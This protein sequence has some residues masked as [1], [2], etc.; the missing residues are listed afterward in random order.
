MAPT[1]DE[2][3]KYDD[4]KMLAPGTTVHHRDDLDAVQRMLRDVP[5]LSVLVYDQTCAAE[6]RR[7]RK[8][9]TFVDPAKRMFINHLVCEGCGDCSV[10]S[11]CISVKP[12]E[13]P[14]GRKRQIDQSDCNKDF[15]CL[16]GFCPSFVTVYG[17]KPRRLAAASTGDD[18]PELPDPVLARVTGVF[19][20][21]VTGIG[22]TGVI[23]IGALLGMA[24]HLEGR[25][26]SVLDFT[27]LAQ[28]NGGVTSHVRIAEHQDMLHAVRIGVGAADLLLA[29]D[30]IVAVSAGAL[31]RVDSA[32]TAAVVNTRVTPT[33]A[34][35]RDTMID[36]SST[37]DLKILETAVRDDAAFVDA[38]SLATALLGDSIA[39]NLFMLGL[40]WQR[41][42]VPLG[43]AALDKA[44][45]LNGTA[46]AANR[47]AFAWGRL[48]AIDPLRV[49]AAAAVPSFT[50]TGIESGLAGLVAVRAADLVT[51]QDDAYAAR[52]RA[53][54]NTMEDAEV[55]VMGSAGDLTDAVARNFFKLMAYKDEYEVARLYSD[56]RFAAQIAAQFE[57]DFKLEFN[58]A[59]PM[60]A[61]RDASTGE[62]RK[63]AYGSWMMHGF[64]LL[65]RMKLF[66]GTRLDIFG[67]QQE[68][69]IERGLIES[70]EADMLRLAS[71]LDRDSHARAVEIARLPDGIRGYGHVKQASLM[72]AAEARDRLLVPRP[73]VLSVRSA[74]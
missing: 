36:L 56:N 8:R 67:Y 53:L 63:R 51:Y 33:S 5:G 29:C 47:K 27:G 58:L 70:Y 43:F 48:A 64:K 35:V 37:R 55:R 38:T 31:S 6:K 34:F 49:E 25:G 59:P 62:L 42:L 17:G 40:A 54:V 45:E 50:D 12:I 73:P 30:M 66:R 21:L 18:F 14:L 71:A 52:Y 24:A 3:E 9:G 10:K 13:T 19:N 39:S 2:P 74:A 65:A 22:G 28:K 32:R 23:T 1:T 44:I 4:V 16:K 68:R 61:K 60:F 41:G 46:V 20:I 11:N 7:R 69:R 15:S 26:A 57:G 72:R